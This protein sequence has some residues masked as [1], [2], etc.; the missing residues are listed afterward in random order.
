MK[1]S[2][3]LSNTKLYKTW[4]SMIN[5]CHNPKAS[6]FNKYGAKGIVVCDSWQDPRNFMSWA[7]VNGYSENLTIERIDFTKEYSPQNCKWIPLKD[8]AKNSCKRQTN[9]SGFVG[10]SYHKQKKKW[11]AR[12]TIQSKRIEIG[13]YDSAEEAHDARKQYFISNNLPELLEIYERQHK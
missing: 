11:I 12:V 7:L 13:K 10:V 4:A 9:T 2:H 3:G 1:Y 6:N 8:Q 5:R